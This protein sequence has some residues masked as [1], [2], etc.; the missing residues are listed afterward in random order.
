MCTKKRKINVS[1]TVFR[2]TNNSELLSA[3]IPVKYKDPGCP[4][5]ACTKGQT[6]INRALLDLRASINLLSFFVYQHLGFG[7]LHPTRITIQL[8]DRVNENPQGETT[9]VLFRVKK[10]IYPVDFIVLKTQPV[11]SPRS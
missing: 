9:D 2:T 3:S 11:L 1:K 4:T 10:F 6:T 7:D 5:I 8:A